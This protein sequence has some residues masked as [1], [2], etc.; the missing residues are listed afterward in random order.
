MSCLA[1]IDVTDCP[2]VG[3]EHAG[4]AAGLANLLCLQLPRLAAELA[5]R[6]RPGRGGR[7][8]RH[9]RDIAK[10]ATSTTDWLKTWELMSE[11]CREAACRIPIEC[12]RHSLDRHLK[13]HHFCHNCS[14]MA[15][16]AYDLL[17]KEGQAYLYEVN[18]FIAT[19][20]RNIKK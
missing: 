16:K 7:C 1:G 19:R 5:A 9:S 14:I 20:P 3:P 12:L 8:V 17:V 4:D 15:N 18:K 11:E 13:K 2:S 6:A 10:P